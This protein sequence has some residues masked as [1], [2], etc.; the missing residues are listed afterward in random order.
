MVPKS[1]H[2]ESAVR[3]SSG[4]D[5]ERKTQKC[6]PRQMACPPGWASLISASGLGFD[7]IVGYRFWPTKRAGLKAMDQPFPV[8]PALFLGLVLVLKPPGFRQ[9]LASLRVTDSHPSSGSF[10]DNS[11]TDFMVS[12]SRPNVSSCRFTGE[13]SGHNGYSA[14]RGTPRPGGKRHFTRRRGGQEFGAE[15]R[16]NLTA[17]PKEAARYPPAEAK[18][19][20]G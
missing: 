15:D 19:L 14:A 12:L 9:L 7:V 16:G 6:F 4:K 8:R 2:A 11:A 17:S 10:L 5:K 20:S 3:G 1:F 18:S 13:P